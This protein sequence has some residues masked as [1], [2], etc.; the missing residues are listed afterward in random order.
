MALDN[1]T[2]SRLILGFKRIF[3]RLEEL[4]AFVEAK[5]LVWTT[6]KSD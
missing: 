5:R 3:L 6:S 4:L 1:V 2:I